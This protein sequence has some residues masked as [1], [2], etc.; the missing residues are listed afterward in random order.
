MS[1]KEGLTTLTDV[2]VRKLET[3]DFDLP[4]FPYDFLDR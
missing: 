2:Q 3:K 1:D 4:F